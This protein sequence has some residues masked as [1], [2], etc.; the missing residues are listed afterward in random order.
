MANAHSLSLAKVWYCFNGNEKMDLTMFLPYPD[1]GKPCKP[2][3]S[4]DSTRMTKA[5][6]IAFRQAVKSGFIPPGKVG[7]FMPYLDEVERLTE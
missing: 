4:A 5:T 1:L 7:A 6:A 2:V 3:G